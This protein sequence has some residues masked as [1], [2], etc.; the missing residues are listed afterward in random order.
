MLQA[1]VRNILGPK[2]VIGQVLDHLRA[3]YT[4]LAYISQEVPQTE[5]QCDPVRM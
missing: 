5:L 1:R 3:A 4:G 2:V